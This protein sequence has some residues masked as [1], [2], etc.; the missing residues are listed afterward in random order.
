MWIS[1]PGLPSLGGWEQQGLVARGSG[2]TA[3]M[4]VS[5]GG[6]CVPRGGSAEESAPCPL[7]AP[8][9]GWQPWLVDTSLQS[10][11]PCHME[12]SLSV[13]PNLSSLRLVIKSGLT[14]IQYG[15]SFT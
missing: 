4:E 14:L 5:A 15:F 11:P 3:V 7:L 9:G 10:L 2:R 13:C 1:F 8:G 6:R 12:L